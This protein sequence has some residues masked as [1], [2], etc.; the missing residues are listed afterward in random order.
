MFWLTFGVGLI[1]EDHH[2]SKYK[3]GNNSVS[4]MDIDLKLGILVDERHSQHI[5]WAATDHMRHALQLCCKYW[6][7]LSLSISETTGWISIQL[8][9][10]VGLWFFL[11]STQFQIPLSIELIKLNSYHSQFYRYS[12]NIV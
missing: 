8:R 11:K 6:N 9:C 10:S 12:G 5:S 2:F 3:H 7:Q 4:F 1:Q